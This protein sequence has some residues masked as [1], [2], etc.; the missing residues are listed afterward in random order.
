MP[1]AKVAPVEHETPLVAITD[2]LS[3]R[4]VLV[5]G[6]AYKNDFDVALRHTVSEEGPTMTGSAGMTLILVTVVASGQVVGV[7]AV[8]VKVK[9][10][11]DQG[12]LLGGAQVTLMVVVDAA[13]HKTG[14]VGDSL[15]RQSCLWQADIFANAASRRQAGAPLS[16]ICGAP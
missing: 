6:Q 4:C 12:L 11:A 7:I 15:K 8:T 13:A 14:H 3:V 1:V 10:P 9:P 5:I 2:T 16:G